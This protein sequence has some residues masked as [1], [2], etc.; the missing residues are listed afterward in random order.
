MASKKKNANNETPLTYK[1]KIQKIQGFRQHIIELEKLEIDLTMK[2][3]SDHGVDKEKIKW[4]ISK[5]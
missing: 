5:L 3:M 4:D 1:Q 2:T